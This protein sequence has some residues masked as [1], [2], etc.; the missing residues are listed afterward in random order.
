MDGKKI[1]RINIRC[2]VTEKEAIERAAKLA[3]IGVSEY[4]LMAALTIY[5]D[6]RYDSILGGLRKIK[7]QVDDLYRFV[8][9]SSEVN[10]M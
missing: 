3:G 9:Q 1:E 8:V 7:N 4:M 10:E 6:S 2:T 5:C